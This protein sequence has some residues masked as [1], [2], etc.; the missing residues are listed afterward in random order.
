MASQDISVTDLNVTSS[1]EEIEKPMT[2][3]KDEQQKQPITTLV[4]DNDCESECSFSTR[5]EEDITRS[6]LEVE[7]DAF[8]RFV[9]RQ[10]VEV[11]YELRNLRLGERPVTG[12]FNRERIETFLN[13]IQTQREQRAPSTQPAAP[14]AH[15]ADINALADRGC[16][17][18][19]LRSTAFRQDLE[20]AIRRSV[21]PRPNASTSQIPPAPSMSRL[22]PATPVSPQQSQARQ[23]LPTLP[24]RRQQQ[25]TQII[26]P[27]AHEPLNLERQERELQAWQTITQLQR[28]MIVIE[29]SDL[30]H[31]QLVS[32]ALESD[33]R[34]HLEHNVLTRFQ[35][36]TLNAQ[37]AP[38]A[39]TRRFQ[40]TPT[41][42]V[43]STVQTSMN[44]SSIN[45]LST[46]LDDMQHMLRLMYSMQMDMQRMLRQEVASSLANASTT[47]T[48]P[49]SHPVSAG[50]CTVCLTEIAD[51]VLYRCGHLCVCYTCGLN[52]RETSS[53]TRMKCPVCRAPVDDILRVYRSSRNEE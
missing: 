2:D 31:R 15:L 7:A 44:S 25:P 9:D 3:S 16:V 49:S 26:P 21:Q 6:I 5:S 8:T 47:T 20:N 35:Q 14:S 42:H 1:S 51:T 48:V 36:G 28:E 22:F 17:T 13:S 53:S 40:P 12:Q 30:V 38:T 32:S 11:M 45:E 34:T 37:A 46:R 19:A 41:P 29:I 33:F 10:R 50:Q 43:R 23:T 24:V 39:D 4:Q 18:S 52:L 27:T